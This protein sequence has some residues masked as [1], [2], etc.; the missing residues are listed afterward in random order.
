MVMSL[1]HHSST[2]AR[3]FVTAPD[4]A[5]EAGI[6]EIGDVIGGHITVCRFGWLFGFPGPGPFVA[7]P[8]AEPGGGPV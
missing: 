4:G 5:Q 8:Y 7:G 2:G 6:A 1:D 3:L